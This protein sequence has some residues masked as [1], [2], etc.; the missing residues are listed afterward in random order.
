MSRDIPEL[1]HGVRAVEVAV[2]EF[3]KSSASQLDIGCQPHALDCVVNARL[4]LLSAT[5]GG[6]DVARAGQ[7]RSCHDL[8]RYCGGLLAHHCT[9][10]GPRGIQ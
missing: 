1:R 10:L 2:N 6:D 7:L 8:L 3:G 5:A 9:V 4:G